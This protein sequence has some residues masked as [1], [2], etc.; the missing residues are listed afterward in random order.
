[1][2]LGGSEV[3]AVVYAVSAS[4][5]CPNLKSSVPFVRKDIQDAIAVEDVSGT[6]IFGREG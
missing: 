6:T 2:W 4:A 5:Y 1:M 3:T